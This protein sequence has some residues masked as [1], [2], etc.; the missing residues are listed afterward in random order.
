MSHFRCIGLIQSKQ[1][2]SNKGRLIF[3]SL[4]LF[5]HQNTD[6]II[7]PIEEF[8]IY[9]TPKKE[10]NETDYRT[11]QVCILYLLLILIIN[12]FI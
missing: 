6:K 9:E 2:G 4:Y 7:N 5:K 8:D 10:S 1:K 12:L 3:S 11:I